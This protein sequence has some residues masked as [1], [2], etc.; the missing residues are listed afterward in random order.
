MARVHTV[1]MKVMTES[2]EGNE[3]MVGYVLFLIFSKLDAMES[4]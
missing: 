3:G 1:A 4:V 2:Q